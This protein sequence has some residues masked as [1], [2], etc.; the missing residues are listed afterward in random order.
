MIVIFKKNSDFKR[1]WTSWTEKNYKSHRSFRGH[2]ETPAIIPCSSLLVFIQ[3]RLLS[4][5]CIK[6]H[7]VHLDRSSL[8][9]KLILVFPPTHHR[10]GQ[11]AN[12]GNVDDTP[13]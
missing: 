1:P 6:Y 5:C 10:K 4:Y 12:K 3:E 7:L 8:R 13:E 2:F 9:C 11:S